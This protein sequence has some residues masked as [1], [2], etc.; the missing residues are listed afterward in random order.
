MRQLNSYSYKLMP[1]MTKGKMRMSPRALSCLQ[2]RVDDCSS[3]SPRE[4]LSRLLP[5]LRLRRISLKAMPIRTGKSLGLLS[6]HSK[7]LPA[8][9]LWLQ[10]PLQLFKPSLKARQ[11]SHSSV[12]SPLFKL[13]TPPPSIT[14]ASKMCF[15]L[16]GLLMLQAPMESPMRKPN[17]APQAL[18]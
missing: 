16:T 11:I 8:I 6:I 18:L 12:A 7:Y 15:S 9:M 1:Q 14:S 2:L 4:L 5:H 17:I 3:C 13:I 10:T